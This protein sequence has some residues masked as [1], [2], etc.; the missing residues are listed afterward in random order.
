MWV[1]G[2]VCVCEGAPKE[3]GCGGDEKAQDVGHVTWCVFVRAHPRRMR[4]EGTRNVGLW[5]RVCL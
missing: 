2:Y 1:F 5:V 4:M 3:D